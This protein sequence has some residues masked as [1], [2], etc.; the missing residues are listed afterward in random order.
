MPVASTRSFPDQSASTTGN[1][2]STCSPTIRWCSNSSSTKCASTNRARAT[3]SSARFTSGSDSLRRSSADCCARPS[4]SPSAERAE[5]QFLRLTPQRFRQRH[6]FGI[7]PGA[8]EPIKLARRLEEHVDHE[9]A[10]IED[11]PVPEV[12][13]LNRQRMESAQRHPFFNSARDSLHLHVGTPSRDYKVISDRLQVRHLHYSQIVR[14][15]LQRRFDRRKR[16]GQCVGHKY[17]E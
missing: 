6:L 9:V 13:A 3:A 5:P 2:A 1:G 12:E 16:L 11:D 14:L 8:F 15:L 10:I 17:S 7:A 4:R